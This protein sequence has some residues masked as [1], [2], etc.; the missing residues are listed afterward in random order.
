MS[1][2]VDGAV[3]GAAKFAQLG[4]DAME[5]IID[6]LMDGVTVDQRHALLVWEMNLGWG[7]LLDAVVAK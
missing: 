6:A 1:T 7:N 4:Q 2:D 3:K 5:K